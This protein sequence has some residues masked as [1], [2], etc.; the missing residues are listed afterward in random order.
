MSYKQRSPQVVAEGGTGAVTLTDGS[1]LVGAGTGAITTSTNVQATAIHGWNGSIIETPAVTVTSD[2]ATITCSVEADGGGDL[3][4]VFSDGYYTW[5]TTP[6]DTVTLTAGTDTS[7]QINYVYLLQSTKTLTASTA[8]WP[9]AEHAPV[10]TVFCETAA[11]LQTKGPYFQQN[12]T[13]H[14]VGTD[15]QGHI[16]HLNF[17]IRQQR[18]T[19]SS[20]VGQ[21]FTITPNGASADNVTIETSQG[22]VLQLHEQTF[23]AFSNPIDYYVVNDNATP[24]TIVTDL[25]ALLTDSTGASMSGKYFSL[26]LWG[27]ASETGSGHSKMYINLPGGS[28]NTQTDLEDDVSGYSNFEIPA[29][30]KSTGF[31][32]AEWKLRHQVASGGTWTS[33]EQI[34]LRGKIPGQ[35]AGGGTAVPTEFDDSLFRIFDDGDDSK[36]IAFQAS[37]IASGNT[38]TITMIDADLDL[39]TVSNSFP[40]DAGTAAPTANALTIT[41]GTLMNTAGAT[42]VVTINADDSVAASV[43]SDSGTATPASNSFS[44]VGTGGISTSGATSIITV[45]GSGIVGGLTWNVETGT[46]VAMVA[47]NGYI[48]NNAGTVTA[49]LPASAAVGDTFRVTGLQGSWVIAQNAGDTIHFGDQSTTTG[50]GGSLASTDSRDAVELVCVVANTD[51]QVI[52]SVGNITIT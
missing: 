1:I 37:G 33:I 27:S 38:R 13:D 22:I 21:T 11:T 39:N 51:F 18:A 20:G 41:G 42:T 23:P 3:T 17:W 40:T 15:Q 6:A 8:G 35:T 47:E 43:G 7:P 45:D 36:K 19:W 26:V 49:T 30:F 31:L 25:N 32:I 34:D 16:A 29:D 10:A 24:Y 14:V 46:S 28:Y 12:W 50:A 44:I 48:A 9:A 5:D 4:V 52:S 2:G